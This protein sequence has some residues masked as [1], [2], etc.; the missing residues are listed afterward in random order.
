LV[1]PLVPQNT[2]SIGRLCVATGTDLHLVQ[3][4]GFSLEDRYLKRAGLDYWPDVKLH[5]HPTLDAALAGVDLTKTAWYSSQAVRPY[6]AF[7]SGLESWFVFGKET[8][9]LGPELR[10]AHAQR[11]YKIPT[12]NLVRSLNLSNSVSIVVY[13]ALARQGFPGLT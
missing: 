1:E 3:P 6:T 11:L 12:T 9:G 2:G 5:V 10:A 13:E 7:D 8:T 4:L